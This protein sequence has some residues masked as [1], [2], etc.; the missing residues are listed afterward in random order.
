MAHDEALAARIRT[1][2]GNTR[3]LTEKKMFGGLAFL[4][5]GNM[6]F[7]ILGDDLMVRVGPDAFDAALA[8]PHTRPMDFTGRPSRGM[9][10]VAPAGVRTQKALASWHERGLAFARNKPAKKKRPPKR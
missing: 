4:H 7:G 2:L 8:R 1:V 3:K 10:Y 6:C 5:D 9:V